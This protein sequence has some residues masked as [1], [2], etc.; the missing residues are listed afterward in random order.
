MLQND[1]AGW[2]VI[3]DRPYNDKGGPTIRTPAPVRR[4]RLLVGGRKSDRAMSH[5]D[6]AA[7]TLGTDAQCTQLYYCSPTWFG[8]HSVR[9][10][11]AP[12]TALSVHLASASR[13]CASLAKAVSF[14]CVRL[15]PKRVFKA[16]PDRT[17]GA[18]GVH[19]YHWNEKSIGTDCRVSLSLRTRRKS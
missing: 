12:T 13:R 4:L 16:T 1:A 15:R 10:G 11:V 2:Q 18:N 5:N 8:G 9:V 19:W 6:E 14:I 3:Y 7:V 17:H